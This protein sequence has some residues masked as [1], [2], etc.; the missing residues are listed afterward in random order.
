MKQKMLAAA[1][2]IAIRNAAAV[3]A[4]AAGK[5]ML[6]WRVGNALVEEHRRAQLKSER[7]LRPAGGLARRVL[8]W[9][10]TASV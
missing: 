6:S 7:L 1:A 9:L 2:G 5:A 8:A 4:M 10:L 3:A